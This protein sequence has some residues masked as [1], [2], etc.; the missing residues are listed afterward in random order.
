M[1]KLL[2]AVDARVGGNLLF[3]FLMV[4]GASLSLIRG[5]GAAVILSAAE[6]G[7]YALLVAVAAFVS[8]IAGFGKIE[9]TRK[10]FPRM[11]VDGHGGEIAA[12]AD[13]LAG[14]VATRLALIGMPLCIASILLLSSTWAL[15]I[16]ATLLLILG[17][18]WNTILASAL[19]AGPN[20]NVMGIS[21]AARAMVTIVLALAGAHKFGFAGAVGGEAAGALL[22]AVLMRHFQ[23]KAVFPKRQHS[24][25][26][27]N[28]GKAFSISGIYFFIGALATA[29]PIYLGRVLVGIGY[30]D[31]I[32][33]MYSFLGLLV[34]S[35]LTVLGISDQITGPR[36]IKEQRSGDA[37]QNRKK[38]L[39]SVIYINIVLVI[40]ICGA[41]FS[42]ILI[43]RFSYFKVK[44][45]IEMN[46]ILPIT[47][48]CIFQI[49]STIDWFLQA[50]D[51]EYFVAI[52]AVSHMI[53]FL[54]LSII[55]IATGIPVIWI[56][57]VHTIAKG[58][59]LAIQFIAAIEK[60]ST[61]E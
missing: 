35:V 17:V 52:A 24:E 14:L 27:E 44:Y 19:R 23:R 50:H 4:V 13:R 36:F 8:S 1:I 53:V 56:L 7:L 26:L 43:E 29:A 39:R 16:F 54:I 31:H 21:T 2:T 55:V 18:A 11:A 59:Q 40:I 20:L 45:N 15:A 42:T 9:E 5:F 49:T 51:Q 22:G 32:L 38:L 33:G 60:T 28:A 12:M 30:S 47:L 3:M 46:V 25:L 58:I 48:Y 34:S 57:W 37:R 10:L 61:T 41:F 6:F